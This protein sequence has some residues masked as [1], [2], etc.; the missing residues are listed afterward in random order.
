M[1]L[2]FNFKNVKKFWV[3]YYK[4][5]ISYEYVVIQWM[6]KIDKKYLVMNTEGQNKEEV[7]ERSRG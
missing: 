3:V 2:N 6:N 1:I 5:K 4:F 7:R